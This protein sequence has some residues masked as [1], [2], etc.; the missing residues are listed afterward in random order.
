MPFN[1]DQLTTLKAF[2]DANAGT[3]GALSDQDAAVTLNAPTETRVRATMNG[4]ELL[5]ATN[6][7]EFNAV[8]VTD[9][10]RQQWLAL[11]AIESIN[12]ANGQVAASLAIDIFGG[13]SATIS[14]L[15]SA[16]QETVSPAATQGLPRVTATDVNM[17]RA[18]P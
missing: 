11:C 14:A 16:R 3:Y 18:L 7:N 10:Q 13:G 8:S 5:A 17:A 6:A 1:Q 9:A 12:P 4:T 15:Q 2:L